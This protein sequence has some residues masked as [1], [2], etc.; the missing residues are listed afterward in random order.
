MR[1]AIRE[2]TAAD[3]DAV[4]G[5]LKRTPEF[6]AL[7]VIVAEEVIDAYLLS[8]E[9]SGYS[10]YVAEVDDV[11]IG[12]IAY[13]STPLTLST[14]DIYWVATAPDFRG[15][16]IG[17]T[18]MRYAEAQ[19]RKADGQLVLLETSGREEYEATRV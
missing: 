14:W 16:G 9:A 4:M 10:V 2:M 17:T 3:K 15:R 19:I 5:I 1:P 13:G 8:P 11:V 18:L 6:N 12:Y 7:D